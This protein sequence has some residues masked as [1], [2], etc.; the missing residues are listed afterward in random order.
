MKSVYV[1]YYVVYTPIRSSPPS[2]SR[3]IYSGCSFSQRLSEPFRPAFLDGQK[4]RDTTFITQREGKRRRVCTKYRN[5]CTRPNQLCIH[6]CLLC[7]LCVAAPLYRDN[8]SGA[9][10]LAL[11]QCMPARNLKLVVSSLKF[12]IDLHT[13]SIVRRA[14]VTYIADLKKRTRRE[15]FFWKTGVLTISLPDLFM[16]YPKR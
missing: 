13:A 10:R 8:R 6:L 7:S 12:T 11:R 15:R 5:C 16:A 3:C 4:Q 14:D 1:Q 9:R 2:M